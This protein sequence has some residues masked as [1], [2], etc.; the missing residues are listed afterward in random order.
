M[1]VLLLATPD[2]VH[3]DAVIKQLK[4]LGT[5]AYCF[6]LSQVSNNFEI[7]LSL[8]ATH[9]ECQF[10]LP[11]GTRLDLSIVNSIWFRRP[12]KVYYSGLPEPWM[13]SMV[14][15]ELGATIH[16][17]LRSLDCL[18]VNHPARDAECSFKLWQ[19]EKARQAS[20]AIP[21]T[22]VTN[23]PAMVADF[24][25]KCN[26]QLVY[27]LI[28]ESTNFAI[29]KYES[30]PGV[31]TLPFTKEDL[32]EHLH[33]VALAPHF[34]QERVDKLYDIRITAIGHKLFPVKIESQ[35]GAGSLDWRLDYS[36]PMDLIELPADVH[37][38]CLTLLHNLGLNFG[39]IDLCV[40]KNGQY[41][42]FEIN[43]AG[44]YLWMEERIEGL[45]LSME[46][47][48]LLIGESEPM[49]PPQRNADRLLPTQ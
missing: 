44:Q 9:N 2:D 13:N 39:A 5:E 32:D 38:S 22:I 1:T 37:R 43:S 24:Y 26:G 14:E 18:F 15:S 30:S 23:A 31:P 49:I 41:I 6:A 20:F 36:V 4:R 10:N 35:Q 19:L 11:D 29:P 12:G 33:Q 42:F 45:E 46:L 34:F 7:R 47:A 28:S 25:D 3:A 48:K 40:D 21:K 17:T 27:K 16:G 8:G